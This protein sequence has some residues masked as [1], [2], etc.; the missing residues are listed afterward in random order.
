M[1]MFIAYPNIRDIQ[2]L[3]ELMGIFLKFQPKT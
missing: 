2:V 1:I 3:V